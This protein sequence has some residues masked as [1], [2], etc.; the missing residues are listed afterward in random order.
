MVRLQS[1]PIRAED[2]VALV[3]ADEDGA[4]AVFLGTVRNHS[5]GRRVLYLDY[6]AYRG[7]AE[8]E[9]ARI[10]REALDRFGVSAIAVV[11]R[12]GRLGIGE[13]S[14]GVAVASAHRAQATDACRFVIDE[15]KRTVP[16]WKREHFEGGGAVWVE[17]PDRQPAR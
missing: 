11:H 13:V 10:E 16:I 14:V 12:S 7:M 9:M 15:L 3:A 8:A 5:A 17:G 2:L 4:V 6:E 1:E